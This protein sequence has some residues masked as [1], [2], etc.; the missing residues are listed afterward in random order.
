MGLVYSTVVDAPRQEVFDWHGRPGAF[1]RLSPPW[2]PM[3]VVVE[4]DS[5]RDGRAEFAL[6]GGLRWVAQHRADSFDPPRRFVDE[7]GSAGPASVPARLAVLSILK[8]RVILTR[9]DQRRP[10]ES[11]A[12]S[13]EFRLNGVSFSRGRSDGT[14]RL[15]RPGMSGVSGHSGT[16]IP[17]LKASGFVTIACVQFADLRRRH[18]TGTGRVGEPETASIRGR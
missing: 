13:S 6:P 5:L 1:L 15:S 3:R 16:A 11:H 14:T 8:V 10:C 4:A 2:Q 18:A 17:K 9:A 7:V 12:V